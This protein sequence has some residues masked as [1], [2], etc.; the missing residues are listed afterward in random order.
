MSFHIKHNTS[1]A[2]STWLAT[3]LCT[4]LFDLRR[5]HG[6]STRLFWLRS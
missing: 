1:H 4:G 3:S 2:P 5:C 6:W